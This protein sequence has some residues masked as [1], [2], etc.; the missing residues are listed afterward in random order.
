MIIRCLVRIF[1][2]LCTQYHKHLFG[3]I[4]DGKMI[5]DEF[6]RIVRDEW[7]IS[8]KIRN[9]IKLHEYVIMPN[10]FHAI[11]EIVGANGRSPVQNKELLWNSKKIYHHRYLHY[12]C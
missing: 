11:V 1:L 3:R 10:H 12:R 2:T 7:E 6:G 8:E 5:L 9:E 4:I